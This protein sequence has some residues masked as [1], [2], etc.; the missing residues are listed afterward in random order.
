MWS[1]SNSLEYKQPL[2]SIISCFSAGVSLTYEIFVFCWFILR[3]LSW[4]GQGVF[5]SRLIFLNLVWYTIRR[6]RPNSLDPS[7][8]CFL[9]IGGCLGW[10]A[11]RREN[12]CGPISN[13]SHIP[14]YPCATV[15][16]CNLCVS[17]QIDGFSPPIKVINLFALKS[18]FS[19][20]RL[21][22]VLMYDGR[23]YFWRKFFNSIL[24][25]WKRQRL[26]ETVHKLFM[27][28]KPVQFFLW[29]KTP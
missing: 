23:S 12:V 28:R 17:I 24:K 29:K 11:L 20:Q 10:F 19:L 25:F 18:G 14:T 15:P 16:N 22:N 9:Y 8:Y 6:E 4:G 1:D 27:K 26:N 21:S 5:C 3:S 2:L 7:S 13:F